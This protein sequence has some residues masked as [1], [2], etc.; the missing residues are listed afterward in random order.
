MSR[1]DAY[2]STVGGRP[3]A[4]SSTA[5]AR[6]RSSA[7]ACATPSASHIIS[8]VR[9]D[10]TFAARKIECFSNQG[11]LRLPRP[12]HRRQGHAARSRSCIPDPNVDGRRLHRVHEPAPP[13]VQCAATASRRPCSPANRIMDDVC[14]VH[15]RRTR[16]SYR[17]KHM[18]PVGFVDGFSTAR[19]PFRHG[20][21]QSAWT[22]ASALDGRQPQ[23][24]RIRKPDRSRAPRR[25]HAPCFWYNTG[26]L[27][28]L[29]G[30]LL[31]PHGPESGRL[32]PAAD[33]RATEIGQGCDT[34]FA[35][36]A[37]DAVGI[38]RCGRARRHGAGHGRHAVRHGRL[39]LAPD[40]RQRHGHQKDGC[41]CSRSSILEYA[42]E[43][44]R[45][46]HCPARH[47]G[48]QDHP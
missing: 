34:A 39:R 14:R 22:R 2:L 29:P 4:S 11:G 26:R 27:A 23:A 10:G 31:V 1:C 45:Q 46:M 16:W 5:R 40:L 42:C 35:Q 21:N 20:L 7:T 25:R 48:R 41:S 19:E 44:T 38:P 36:M 24:P 47:R 8:W 3:P 15:R 37:A 30:E 33:R 32:H 28:H 17:R 43:L 12:R 18:M 13:R 6:R 9:P